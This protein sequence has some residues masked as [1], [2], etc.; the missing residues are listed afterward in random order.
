MKSKNIDVFYAHSSHRESGL[1]LYEEIADYFLSIADRD[2][3]ILDVDTFPENNNIF[4]ANLVDNMNLA[5][6]MVCDI[7]PDFIPPEHIGKKDIDITPCI[8]SNVMYEL[9]YFECL[10][11]HKNIIL[12]MDNTV[13]SCVPSILRGHYITRYEGIQ[14][15]DVI[16]ERIKDFVSFHQ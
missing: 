14:D 6:I 10:K 9:G 11:D 16:I 7:T 8:N 13:S 12:I 3:N 4:L 5:D 15:K 1:R 2:I